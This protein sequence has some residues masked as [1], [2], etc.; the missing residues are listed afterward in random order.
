MIKELRKLNKYAK[1]YYEKGCLTRTDRLR[2][3]ES[4][5]RANQQVNLSDFINGDF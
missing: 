5:C 1:D 2:F 3:I 4:Y